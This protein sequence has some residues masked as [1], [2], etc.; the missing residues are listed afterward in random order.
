MKKIVILGSSPVGVQVIEDIRKRDSSSKIT[1]ISFDGHFPYRRDLFASFISKKISSENIFCHAKDYYAQNN[2]NV[3]LD[4]KISRVNVKRKKIY[5]E[6]NDPIDY[7]VLII[8]DTP[9]NRFPSIKGANKTGIYGYKKLSDIEQILNVLPMLDTVVVQSD[10]FSG[11]QAAAAFASLDKEVIFISP[12]NSFLNKHFEGEV[13]QWVVETIDA[14]GIQSM[15]NS[16][17]TEILGEKDARAIRLDTGKVYSTQ[18]ILF[19]ETDEDLRLFSNSGLQMDKKIEVNAQY[20]S[21]I[22]EIFVVDQV[23]INALTISEPVVPLSI[24]SN[25]GKVVAAA[26]SDQELTA[27]IPILHWDVNIEGLT[28]DVLGR[29]EFSGERKIVRSFQRESESY[30]G[31]YFQNNILVGAILINANDKKNELLRSIHEKTPIEHFHEQGSINNICGNEEDS[32]D[33][34]SEDISTELVDN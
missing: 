5:I 13:L 15:R 3:V 19:G 29:T 26:I 9:E 25:Q 22:D 7:D 23:C 6:D 2:V 32:E 11:L 28:I 1:I 27:E 10:H 20:R 17:I 4:K 33:I 18:V 16:K 8:T 30:T 34:N 14:A 31:L 12:H 21:N 24:L